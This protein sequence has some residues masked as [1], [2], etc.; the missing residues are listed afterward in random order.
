MGPL[1]ASQAS[2]LINNDIWGKSASTQAKSSL[3]GDIF[4][5]SGGEEATGVKAETWLFETPS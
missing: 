5:A 3:E 4:L 2:E 1:E